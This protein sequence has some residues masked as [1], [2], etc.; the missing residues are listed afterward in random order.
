MTFEIIGG[1]ENSME[2]ADGASR[3]ESLR[4]DWLMENGMCG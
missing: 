4:S 2:K 3:K 1:S